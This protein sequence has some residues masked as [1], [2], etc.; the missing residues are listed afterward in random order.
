MKIHYLKSGV[1]VITLSV[2]PLKFSDGTIAAGQ[3]EY[4]VKKL[5]LKR[6]H[7]EHEPV[8]GMR[9]TSSNLVI[10][11]EQISLLAFLCQKADIVILPFQIH[12]ALSKQGIR[13]RFPN[14][15]VYNP[16]KETMRLP[17][18]KKIIDINNWGY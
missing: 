12:T 15:L 7:T 10:S 9:V 3:D 11:E 18:D 17:P 5:I 13:N 8:A 16:T 6:V 14:A 4:L 1:T 2:H